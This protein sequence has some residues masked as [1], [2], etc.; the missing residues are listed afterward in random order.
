MLADNSGATITRLQIEVSEDGGGT[1][2]TLYDPYRHLGSVG[3][4]SLTDN[5]FSYGGTEYTVGVG[6]GKGRNNTLSG[7]EPSAR[8]LERSVGVQ[9]MVKRASGNA[10]EFAADIR[11]RACPVGHEVLGVAQL[12]GGHDAGAAA[13][14]STCTGGP[15]TLADALA[16]DIALHFCKRRLDLHKGAA[17]W[18]PSVN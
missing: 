1:W 5:I 12:F 18:W 8:L 15:D 14:A 6:C 9:V 2:S 16:H 17:W 4:G 11:Y 13:F 3:D 7:E 10:A